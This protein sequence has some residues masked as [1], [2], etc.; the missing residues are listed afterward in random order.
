M[1]KCTV[2]IIAFAVLFNVSAHFR[3]E[4]GMFFALICRILW[5]LLFDPVVFV[6]VVAVVI[7]SYILL[8]LIMETTDEL[9]AAILRAKGSGVCWYL[10]NKLLF[11][12]VQFFLA[13]SKSTA[14]IRALTVL[15]PPF[16]E[17]SFK[18]LWFALSCRFLTVV[19]RS[20]TVLR[21]N[22]WWLLGGINLALSLVATIR[23]VWV[24]ILR[25]I[26]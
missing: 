10:W 26:Y 9:L 6:I 25:S 14:D 23:F 18:V 8:H 7:I 1:S 4:F 5:L 24:I 12:E 17:H 11:V 13:V 22:H 19:L 15:F 16:A 3:L 21:I 2:W 20:V